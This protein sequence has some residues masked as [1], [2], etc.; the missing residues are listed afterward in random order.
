MSKTIH[1]ATEEKKEE[2]KIKREKEF[3][4]ELFRVS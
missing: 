1:D 2:R 4:T 3:K